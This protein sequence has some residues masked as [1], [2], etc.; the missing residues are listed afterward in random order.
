MLAVGAKPGGPFKRVD[1]ATYT[2]S[3]ATQ[4]HTARQGGKRAA[5]P[6]AQAKP[7]KQQKPVAS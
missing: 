7:K 5:K 2:L 1:K 6:R 3:D 4:S